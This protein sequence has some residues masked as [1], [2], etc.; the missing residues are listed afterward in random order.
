MTIR[1]ELMRF[2]EKMEAKMQSHDEKRGDSWKKESLSY[3]IVRLQQEVVELHEAISNNKSN[4]EISKEAVDIANF[5]M[6]IFDMFNR[7]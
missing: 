7:E 6:M 4:D 5:S 3:L 2:V 1:P